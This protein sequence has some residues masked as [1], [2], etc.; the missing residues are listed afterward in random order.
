MMS[1]S[2]TDKGVGTLRGLAKA[3][4]YLSHHNATPSSELATLRCARRLRGSASRDDF[5]VR[6]LYENFCPPTEASNIAPPFAIV[7]TAIPLW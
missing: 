2:D 7:N 1:S 5:Y 3:A 6:G 4:A